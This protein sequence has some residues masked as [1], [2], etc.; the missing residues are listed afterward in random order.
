[1]AEAVQ[2]LILQLR[3]CSVIGP[4]ARKR[5]PEERDRGG[6]QSWPAIRVEPELTGSPAAA[7]AA[8]KSRSLSDP[9]PLPVHLPFNYSTKAKAEYA[10]AVVNWYARATIRRMATLSQGK[11]RLWEWDE[12]ITKS[13]N[14]STQPLNREFFEKSSDVWRTRNRIEKFQQYRESSRR[15]DDDPE[16]RKERVLQKYKG[17]TLEKADDDTQTLTDTKKRELFGP[18]VSI[19]DMRKNAMALQARGGN[20]AA[21]LMYLLNSRRLTLDV[22]RVFTHKDPES[23]AVRVAALEY[24]LGV[25]TE[26]SYTLSPE[27][28]RWLVT[29][30]P[31]AADIALLCTYA[32]SPDNVEELAAAIEQCQKHL[33]RNPPGNPSAVYD[34]LQHMMVG[35]WES[36][37]A[38]WH[39]LIPLSKDAKLESSPKRLVEAS[40]GFF[41]L[42]ARF[43]A[44][45]PLAPAPAPAPAPAADGAGLPPQPDTDRAKR[46]QEARELAEERERDYRRRLEQ[47]RERYPDLIYVSDDENDTVDLVSDDEQP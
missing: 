35:L 19:E 3:G 6:P 43:Q 38:C 32:Q 17:I 27:I 42:V 31:A 13:S 5:P 46:R 16:V 29:K 34:R 24:M 33:V 41:M 26:S 23:P 25:Y 22:L 39:P 12:E 36:L 1:M 4:Q 21:I 30:V 9:E 44:P 14:I 2:Q 37:T 18:S 15:S 47:E 8:L 11:D 20:V 45:P 40:T 28:Q 10:R 7:I